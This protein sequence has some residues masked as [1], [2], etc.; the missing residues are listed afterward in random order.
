M[1]RLQLGLIGSGRAGLIHGA[2]I[3][4]RIE[5]AELAAVCDAN[6]DNLRAAA[7]ELGCLQTVA[8]YRAVCADPAIDAVVIVTPTFLH[9]EIAC[10]AAA[11]GKHVFLEK[12]MAVT[13][14]ECRAIEEACEA[15]GVKLQIGSQLGLLDPPG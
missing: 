15:A 12:P 13:A 9:A 3:A 8:D 11:A 14:D 10:A 1:K 6:P 7:A 5:Q 4:R 2:N